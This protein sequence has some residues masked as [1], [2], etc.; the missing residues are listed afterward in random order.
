MSGARRDHTNAVREADAEHRVGESEMGR[1]SHS[2]H[3]D[4]LLEA[5]IH[6][7]GLISN[8]DASGRHSTQSDSK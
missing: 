8:A 5:L 2:A 7:S 3:M 6:V 1:F 4:L